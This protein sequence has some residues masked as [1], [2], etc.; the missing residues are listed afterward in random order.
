MRWTQKL[1]TE[2]AEEER[3]NLGLGQW[4]Q[5]DP[6]A[7]CEEHGI[8]VYPLSQIAS[9]EAVQHFTVNR[10]S[11]WS[12]ALIPVGS[13]RVI[14]ENDQHSPVRRRSNI[15]HELGHFL[16]EHEFQTALLGETHERQFD[17][18]LEKQATYLAGE[19][20]V[21]SQSVEQMAF[22]NWTNGQVAAA[23]G[24]SEQ[25][26]QMRMY[27]QRVR[28]TRANEKFRRRSA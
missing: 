27:G 4:D 21:P 25:F 1:M 22:K 13:A 10:S 23:F 6:Y 24:V 11:T 16:L 28:A 14:V 19:L 3:A 8:P 18:K 17:A 2:L 5:L 20:L 12:A 9:A 7:L 26:A 15:G